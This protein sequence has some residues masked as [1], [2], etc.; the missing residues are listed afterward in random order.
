MTF[1]FS[2]SATSICYG[3]RF[4]YSDE[5]LRSF[6]LVDGALFKSESRDC[7]ASVDDAKLGA[8]VLC[9]LVFQL[10]FITFRIIVVGGWD[11]FLLGPGNF[12]IGGSWMML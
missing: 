8:V 11:S 12:R 10:C 4:I 3:T 7:I 1:Q 5:C 6:Q 9:I 2:L